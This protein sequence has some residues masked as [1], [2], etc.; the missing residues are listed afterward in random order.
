MGDRTGASL[1]DNDFGT[2]LGAAVSLAY[3]ISHIIS[4]LC[5]CLSLLIIGLKH[6]Y[7]Q[8]WAL[9]CFEFFNIFFQLPLAIN[10]S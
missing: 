1:G 10:R 2:A 6:N 4:P 7:C 5:E 8:S 3:L 9:N